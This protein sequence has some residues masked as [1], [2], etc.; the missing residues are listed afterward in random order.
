MNP[1]P[2][3]TKALCNHI[4]RSTSQGQMPNWMKQKGII[5]VPCRSNFNLPFIEIL[6]HVAFLISQFC[7][8]CACLPCTNCNS[9]DLM[10]PWY[11]FTPSSW[12]MATDGGNWWSLAS[13][14]FCRPCATHEVSG[15]WGSGVSSQALTKHCVRVIGRPAIAI[16][17]LKTY[18]KIVWPRKDHDTSWN[19]VAFGR[20]GC[21]SSVVASNSDRQG[22]SLP[23][24]LK[25]RTKKSLIGEVWVARCWPWDKKTKN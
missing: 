17:P 23:N 20:V 16:P 15:T 7:K 22:L 24:N 9:G 1:F 3:F 6:H 18:W 19:D 4:I 10:I 5:Q 21:G 14:P 11:G 13:A 8:T 12:G 25:V 2:D